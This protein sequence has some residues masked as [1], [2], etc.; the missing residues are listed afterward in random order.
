MLAKN[1]E[2]SKVEKP[3]VEKPKVEIPAAVKRTIGPK[4]KEKWK[5]LPKKSKGTSSEAFLSSLWRARHTR[6]NFFRLQALEMADSL[7][8]QDNSKRLSKGNQAKGENDGQLI[9]DVMEMLKN[10]SSCLAS[11]T[12]RF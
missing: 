4:P 5:S 12:P 10:I 2:K 6:P 7:R 11:F 1:V 8:G 3:K 9:G